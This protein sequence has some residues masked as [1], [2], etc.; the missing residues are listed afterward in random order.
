MLRIKICGI[1]TVD[2]ALL[3]VD[4]GADAI[5]LNFYRRS[6]R[7]VDR[8]TA[9]AIAAAVAGRATVVGVFVNEPAQSI[10]DLAAA[11]PLDLVQLHG[12]EPPTALAELGPGRAIKAF[13]LGDE[14]L[15]PIRAYLTAC[16]AAGSEPALILFDARVEGAYGGT[17]RTPSWETATAYRPGADGPPLILAGGLGP[18][19]VGAAIAAVRP[20]AVD[21]AS[22]V[23]SSPGQK[24]PEKTRL[25]VAR[26]RAAFE[27][28]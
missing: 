21:T 16:Q 22:G 24:S 20:Q 17:G 28:L 14:G 12:D 3:A 4:A 25:F 27:R 11:V 6:P 7:F 15:P 10:R 8:N 19:N 2:D 1:T 9:R 26:A 23:E 5:G 13:R 18:D